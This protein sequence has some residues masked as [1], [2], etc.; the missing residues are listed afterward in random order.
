MSETYEFVQWFRNS[1]PYI[2]AFRG[3]TFVL[4]FGGE[5]VLEPSFANLVH[6]IA[7]LHSLGVRLVLVHGARPQID[8]Q[9]TLR[10][11]GSQY[12]KGLRI[13][14]DTALSC[15]KHAVGAVRVEVESLLTMGLANSPMAGARLRVASGNFVTAKPLGVH[16]G[17]DYCHTGEVRRVDANGIN[18]LLDQGSIALLSP[19]GYSPTGEVFNLRAEDVAVS[20]ARALKAAKLIYLADDSELLDQTGRLLREM[21]VPEV[22]R[23]LQSSSELSEATQRNLK[24]AISLCRSGVERIHFVP[25]QV[26]G[27]VLQ[28]LFTRDGIGTLIS[29]NRFEGTRPAQIEDVGGILELIA[30][31]ERDGTMVRRSRELLEMEIDRFTVIERDGMVI[32]CAALYPYAQTGLA[33]LACLAIHPDYRGHGRGDALLDYIEKQAA[34][35]G[36]RQLFVLTTRTAHWFIER[37]FAESELAALPVEKQKLYNYQRKSKIFIKSL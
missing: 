33:E 8:Q 28:E 5:C 15:V 36:I 34:T 1:A 20:T 13:T 22:E 11:A 30:P 10:G 31:F 2:N 7:L 21:T 37:G 17:I 14:D 6:D 27:A 24:D 25:R 26:D 19:L 9:L 35:Q 18:A 32:G 4:A 16:D 23:F 3:R 29:A 12:H